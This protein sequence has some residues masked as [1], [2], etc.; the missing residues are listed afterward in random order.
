LKK[1][2]KVGIRHHDDS[3]KSKKWAFV[4]MTIQEKAKSGH[5]SS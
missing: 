2:Q 4:I 1:K 3:R 5:S